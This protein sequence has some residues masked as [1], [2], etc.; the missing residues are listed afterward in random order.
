MAAAH[1]LSDRRGPWWSTP[2]QGASQQGSGS[3][4]RCGWAHC[5]IGRLCRVRRPVVPRVL[6]AG[7]NIGDKN[8]DYVRAALGKARARIRAWRL[9]RR[10]TARA[11]P[12]LRLVFRLHRFHAV[13][14]LGIRIGDRGLNSSSLFHSNAHL[15]RSPS[16][17]N[18]RERQRQGDQNR[19]NGAQAVQL[20]VLP[21][22]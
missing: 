15:P 12:V 2:R 9:R 13:A 20:S 4:R 7:F 10:I 3:G 8:G 5:P 21:K 14:H 16:R 18:R 17:G 11:I 22:F 19:K 6:Q 1:A